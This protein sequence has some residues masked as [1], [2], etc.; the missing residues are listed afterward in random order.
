MQS[1][2]STPEEYFEQLP[3]DRKEAM[4]K[5]RKE[6]I[7]NIPSGFQERMSYGMVGYVVP[8]SVFPKG[9]HC[10]P[11]LPLPFANIAS[12]KNHIAFYHMGL[13]G[14]PKL[15]EWFVKE[16]PKH[17]D[18][19]LDMGKGCVRFKKPE[20]IPFKLMGELMGKMTVK[21]WTTLYEENLERSR[22]TGPEKRAVK[23]QAVKKTVK[24]AVKKK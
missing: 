10:D 13:Y 8:H 22:G 11:K 6:I 12:Q 5:L 18:A 23:K 15:L 20:K 14:S 3:E 7:K 16:Y 9:Y 19:K 2:A 4:L 24:K 17:T 1:K 21:D